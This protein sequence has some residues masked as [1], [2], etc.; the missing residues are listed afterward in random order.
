MDLS[1]TL[2]HHVLDKMN[3]GSY[4]LQW[5]KTFFSNLTSCLLNHGFKADLFSYLSKYRPEAYKSEKLKNPPKKIT[6]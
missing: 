2:L 1:H 6:E 3:F 4:F 5:I